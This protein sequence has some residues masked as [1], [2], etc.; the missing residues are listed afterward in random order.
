MK[1]ESCPISAELVNAKLTRVYAIV[2]LFSLGIYLF[3]PFKEIILFTTLD[4]VIRVIFSVKYS[5]ICTVI[6]IA[7]KAIDSPSHMVNAGPKKF[8]AKVGLIFSTLMTLGFIFNF[9]ILSYLVGVLFF[10]AVGLEAIFGYC[11]ACTMYAYV[12]NWLKK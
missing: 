5:P 12:P 1:N 11:L 7:L 4:F 3:T 6:K 2:T 10:S 8:A 9:P